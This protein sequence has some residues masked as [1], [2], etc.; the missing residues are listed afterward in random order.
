[1]EGHAFI[2]EY[3]KLR[4]AIQQTISEWDYI[5]DH[6]KLSMLQA[7]LAS[8]GSVFP[9]AIPEAMAYL[10][11]NIGHLEKSRNRV[12]KLRRKNPSTYA[13]NLD[14]Q[15]PQPTGEELA[16]VPLDQAEVDRAV[17]KFYEEEE[18]KPTQPLNIE[19]PE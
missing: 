9:S 10:K 8:T 3:T 16:Y 12:R 15:P 14:G 5:P 19:V 18:Q 17:A 11:L 7:A 6:E 4:V 13:I 2:Q 1:M